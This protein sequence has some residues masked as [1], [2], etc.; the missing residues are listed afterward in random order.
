MRFDNS[1]AYSLEDFDLNVFIETLVSTNHFLV[2]SE[3]L[4]SESIYIVADS[5]LADRPELII[6]LLTRAFLYQ[7]KQSQT[8]IF[9]EPE[10]RYLLVIS[11]RAPFFW[12]GSI[13]EIDLGPVEFRASREKN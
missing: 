12:N 4:A 8:D 6:N 9:T 3:Y 11:P 10:A 1:S 5:Q 13:M 2:Y 7:D